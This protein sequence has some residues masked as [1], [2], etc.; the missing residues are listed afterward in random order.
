MQADCFAMVVTT[1]STC[2]GRERQEGAGG[3]AT[4]EGGRCTQGRAAAAAA[5][6]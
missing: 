2:A 3:A 5:L 6:V 4:P 1:C